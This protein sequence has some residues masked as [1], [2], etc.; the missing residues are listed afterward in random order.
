MTPIVR[1]NNISCIYMLNLHSK[2]YLINELHNK[3]LYT[4]T[5]ICNSFFF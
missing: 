4:Q 2:L 1:M 5:Q 3:Y